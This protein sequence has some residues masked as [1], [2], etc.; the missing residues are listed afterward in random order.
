MRGPLGKSLAMAAALAAA[1]AAGAADEDLGPELTCQQFAQETIDSDPEFNQALQTYLRSVYGRL[2]TEAMG[3]WTLG[4][5]VGAVHS[6]S[7]GANR[8]EP[9]T[10]DAKTFELSLQKL[11][12]GT[13]TR[14]KMS[15]TNGL[16]DLTYAELEL[17]GFGGPDLGQFMNTSDRTST[18]E[19][20]LS[21]VQPLL[22][23]AF[24][25][26]DR[27]PLQA[28]DLQAR[29][30]EL[31][32]QEAWE[33]RL[34]RLF[35]AYLSWA[36]AQENVLAYRQIAR[37]LQRVEAQ[38]GRKVR[39]GVAERSDLLRTR[40]NILR[41]QGLLVS[42]EGNFLNESA[43]VASLRAGRV[44]PP[45]QASSARPKLELELGEC[46]YAPP[47]PQDPAVQDLRVLAK[48][49][50]LREQLELQAAVTGNQHLPNLD[51]VGNV[52]A[53]GWTPD[54]SGGYGHLDRKDYSVL[55]SAQYPL[56]AAQARGEEG[57]ARAGLAELDRSLAVTERD[58]TLSLQQMAQ[59]IR[60]QEAILRL[61][62]EQESS[63]EERLRLD[64]RNYRIG[65][66]D[67]FYLIDS[68]NALTTARLQRV[69]SQ[70]QLQRLKLSYLS[71]SDQLLG[72]FP[73]LTARLKAAEVR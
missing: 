11:F 67:T 22:K 29:A 18:P 52:A 30:A 43:R 26:A 28:A 51:L 4:A 58:L 20:T 57:K 53:K 66:L 70:I 56:G 5:G 62:Q 71:L 8:F 35:G 49:R 25:L 33:N 1:T 69:Q 21:L 55:L 19:V 10:V 63:A 13:G 3:A 37:D 17:G 42:A 59:S 27:F 32:V 31:D 50:L 72:R 34:E 45:D 61:N 73:S 2:T 16:S 23:N 65:R 9:K 12:L 54:H 7:L 15:H 14:L 60:D 68:T 36:A 46:P 64:E 48:L 39:A 44:L 6:E 47:A 24:G 38:V 40:E 41:Y